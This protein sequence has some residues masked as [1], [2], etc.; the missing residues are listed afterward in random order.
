MASTSEADELKKKMMQARSI[1]YDLRYTHKE[2]C[3]IAEVGYNKTDQ[4]NY[5][6]CGGDF[7]HIC[8]PCAGG[9]CE[10]GCTCDVGEN[11]KKL[12]AARK[13]LKIE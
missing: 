6:M 7:R 12:V 1:L 2:H 3:H 5:C 4:R 11:N 10:I 9:H 8:C 13:L